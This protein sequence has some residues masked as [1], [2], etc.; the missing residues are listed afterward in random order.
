MFSN[1]DSKKSIFGVMKCSNCK[2]ELRKDETVTL[3]VKANDLKGMTQLASWA[4]NQYKLCE[5]CAKQ[6]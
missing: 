3:K 5:T 6:Q 4:D 2:N 1:S